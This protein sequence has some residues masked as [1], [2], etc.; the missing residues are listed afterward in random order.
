M[1]DVPEASFSGFNLT[2]PLSEGEASD[3]SSLRI[4][5]NGKVLAE[6]STALRTQSAQKTEVKRVNGKLTLTW[7]A[8]AY[9]A[10]I[11]RDAEGNILAMDESGEVVLETQSSA[12]TLTFSDGLRSHEEVLTF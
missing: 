9:D 10:V 12:L 8:S 3:L 11:V 1:A 7:D 2:V 5:R 4:E 6:Q